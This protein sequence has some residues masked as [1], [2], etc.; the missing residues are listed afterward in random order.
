[1]KH[2][3]EIK[4]K[5]WIDSLEREPSIHDI[6]NYAKD[7]LELRTICICLIDKD[8]KFIFENTNNKSEL[9]T[10]SRKDTFD[11]FVDFPQWLF[12]FVPKDPITLQ[13]LYAHKDNDYM[14]ADELVE[15]NS[16]VSELVSYGV[17]NSEL[18]FSVKSEVIEGSV[19][20][21]LAGI[22]EQIESLNGVKINETT[23]D[24]FEYFQ[25]NELVEAKDDFIRKEEALFKV[26][27]ENYSS[28]LELLGCESE[29]KNADEIFSAFMPK[30]LKI[31]GAFNL[32]Y[33]NN[34]VVYS[35]NRKLYKV[36]EDRL[37]N[38]EKSKKYENSENIK[39]GLSMGFTATKFGMALAVMA[40]PPL[41]LVSAGME[42]AD[43][44]KDGGELAMDGYS[45]TKDKIEAF[46]FDHKVISDLL[47]SFEKS[48][49]TTFKSFL[50]EEFKYMMYNGM[51]K[52]F[53]KKLYIPDETF[54]YLYQQFV[55]EYILSK[56]VDLDLSVMLQA[57]DSE[58]RD[59][60]LI[61]YIM[62]NSTVNNGDMEEWNI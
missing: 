54:E 2:I 44:I 8:Q 6:Y 10:Q 46:F 53:Q 27:L 57:E 3:K 7:D 31:D 60:F 38:E 26:N 37:R 52:E 62:N 29:L 18:S 12:V 4:A 22:V 40:F 17:F 15:S 35:F 39:K 50:I 47:K 51:G 42:I 14:L 30:N 56:V 55:Q 28:I 24:K 16:Y 41:A 5:K 1:M 23:K 45:L 61:N 20:S 43:N 58:D 49:Q 36:I 59:V 19:S 34:T 25:L 11:S 48:D 9:T 33:I 32:T 21:F 13:F